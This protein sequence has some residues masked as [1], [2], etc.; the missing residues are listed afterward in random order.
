MPKI[1]VDREQLAEIRELISE[2]RES[3]LHDGRL[4]QL[5]HASEDA[6]LRRLAKVP[7]LYDHLILWSCRVVEEFAQLVATIKDDEEKI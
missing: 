1:T 4:Q 2:G 6:E 7:F 5:Y 3:T